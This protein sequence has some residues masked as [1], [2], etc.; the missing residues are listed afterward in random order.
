VLAPMRAVLAGWRI[1]FDEA[2]VAFDRTSPDG[3]AEA[4]RK[5]RTLAGNYQIL[6]QE[7]RL[8]IPVVNPVW[9]QYVSH[10]V[11]RLI[12]PWALIGAFVSSAALVTTAWIYTMA[13]VSQGAFYGLA[14]VGAWLDS[15]DRHGRAP[16]SETLR[17]FPVSA[18]E[19]GAR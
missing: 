7:P 8:L 11:G 2:A 12:V 18:L 19:K 17:E 6:V 4:R 10:K 16:A 3:A 15:R 9:W 5:R 14:I 13:F 1:V